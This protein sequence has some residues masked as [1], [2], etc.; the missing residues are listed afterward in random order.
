VTVLDATQITTEDEISQEPEQLQEAERTEQSEQPEQG[1]P[2]DQADSAEASMETEPPAPAP[3]PAIRVITIP[4]PATCLTRIELLLQQPAEDPKGWW[5]PGYRITRDYDTFPK[6]KATEELPLHPDQDDG[7]ESL[8]SSIACAAESAGWW[9][10]L[11]SSDDDAHAAEAATAFDEWVQRFDPAT[12]T[13]AVFDDA[14]PGERNAEADGPAPVEQESAPS[15]VGEPAQVATEQQTSAAVAVPASSWSTAALAVA[16]MPIGY[17]VTDEA[18]IAYD[19]RKRSLEEQIGQLAIEEANLK[20]CLKANREA[21]AECVEELSKHKARGPEKMPL[22]DRKPAEQP[23]ATATIAGP[24]SDPAGETTQVVTAEQPAEVQADECPKGGRH[25]ISDEGDCCRKCFEPM[26]TALQGEQ[27]PDSSPVEEG[28]EPWRSTKIADLP[29]LTEKIVEVLDGHNI[30]TL[31]DWVD[32]PKKNPG[33]EYT[34]MKGVTEKRY[35]K[36]MDVVT[37][38]TT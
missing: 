30:R 9:L 36:I 28:K 6:D 10:D 24:A 15:T 8:G 20:V 4:L 27:P 13:E 38:A 26:G 37:K 17:T 23:Q 5:R 11:N 12:A 21:Q 16:S 3:G 18:R 33:Y 2:T 31:G 19:T 34:Q 22:F 29:G 7:Y 32:W 1:E 25:E 14:T 35:E